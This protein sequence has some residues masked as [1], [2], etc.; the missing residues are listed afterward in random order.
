MAY[1]CEV[2]VKFHAI[3]PKQ[4]HTK[5]FFD[6]DGDWTRLHEKVREYIR[7][8]FKSGELRSYE[9]LNQ[10]SYRVSDFEY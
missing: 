3:E 4:T 5:T 10:A 8:N 2:T 1:A 9:Q 7:K 6:F